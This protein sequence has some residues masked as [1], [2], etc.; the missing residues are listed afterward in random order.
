MMDMT[1]KG[2]LP[3]DIAPERLH[4]AFLPFGTITDVNIPPDP[5][6]RSSSLPINLHYPLSFRSRPR[7]LRSRVDVNSHLSRLCT[8]RPRN[9]LSFHGVFN[10]LTV[11]RR[12]LVDLIPDRNQPEFCLHHLCKRVLSRRC[13]R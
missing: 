2:N 1:P 5:Q 3:P 10:K 8:G 4:A 7:T 9:T 11:N 6:T 13:G 12:R